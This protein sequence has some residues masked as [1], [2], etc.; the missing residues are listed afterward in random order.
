MNFVIIVKRNGLKIKNVNV[1][2]S[3]CHL[4]KDCFYSNSCF[5]DQLNNNNYNNCIN[6]YNNNN[7]LNKN[8]NEIDKIYY[9]IEINLL[10]SKLKLHFLE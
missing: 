5:L 8:N 6:N 9:F 1:Q 4:F 10:L 2:K 3:K 7:K